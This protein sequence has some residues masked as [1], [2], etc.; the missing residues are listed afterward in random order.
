MF[1]AEEKLPCKQKDIRTSKIFKY[2]FLWGALVTEGAVIV[3][4]PREL[5]TPEREIRLMY[6]AAILERLLWCGTGI[7]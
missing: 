4:D 6:S 2:D 7:P 5:T 3:S 1:V